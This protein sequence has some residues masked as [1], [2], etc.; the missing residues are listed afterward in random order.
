MQISKLKQDITDGL[1]FAAAFGASTIAGA[2]DKIEE[3][4]DPFLAQI[5]GFLGAVLLTVRIL[6]G[7][8]ESEKIK[9]ETHS[10]DLDNLAKE[11]EATKKHQ[12]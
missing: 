9:A 1:L 5:I 7:W 6:K 8:R 3:I 2:A 12:T 10:I 4:K 11:R